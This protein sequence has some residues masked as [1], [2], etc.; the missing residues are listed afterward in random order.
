MKIALNGKGSS[1]K[2]KNIINLQK[3]SPYLS[4]KTQNNQ[5][6]SSDRMQFLNLS[7]TSLDHLNYGLKNPYSIK[8]NKVQLDY[9]LRNKYSNFSQ[10]EKNNILGILK[11]KNYNLN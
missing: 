4:N 2:S 3:V 9:N 10:T 7:P 8:N 5:N 1:R 11:K 6:F